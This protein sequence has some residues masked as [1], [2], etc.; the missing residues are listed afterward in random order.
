MVTIILIVMTRVV[1][2]LLPFLL[3]IKS[4]VLENILY[5]RKIKFSNMCNPTEYG[6]CISH[7]QCVVF[8]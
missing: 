4:L 3:T 6:V 8:I 5:R 2:S 7:H 1:I